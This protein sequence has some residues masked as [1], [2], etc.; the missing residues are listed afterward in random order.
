MNKGLKLALMV[1]VAAAACALP[2]FAG[3]LP[4]CAAAGGCVITTAPEPGT[5]VMLASGI[6]FVFG[7]RHYLARKK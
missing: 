6:G 4:V 5:I 1:G 2:V 3:Q 7:A